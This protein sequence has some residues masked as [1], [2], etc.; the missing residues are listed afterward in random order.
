MFRARNSLKRCKTLLV[1][2]RRVELLTFALRTR[3]SAKLSYCPSRRPN[4]KGNWLYVKFDP[5]LLKTTT[6]RTNFD[7]LRSV[8]KY[9]VGDEINLNEADFMLL[10]WAFFA[11]IE[12]KYL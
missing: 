5:S 6:L 3:G 1:E 7:P 4:Y 2:Q 9:G 8:L 11:E 10:S 12:S